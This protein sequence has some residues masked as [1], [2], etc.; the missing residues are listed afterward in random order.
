[1]SACRRLQ[2]DPY[3]SPCTKFKSEW[4]KD[5]NIH[6][7]TLN[8]IEKKLGSSLEFIGT[9]EHFLDITLVAQFLGAAIN[10]WDLLK[11]QSF[12]KAKDTVYKTKW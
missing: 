4:I 9:E 6:L 10:K 3:L 8:V 5:L 11:P 12:L 1:M 7:V 2:I